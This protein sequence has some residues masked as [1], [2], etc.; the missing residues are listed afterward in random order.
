MPETRDRSRDRQLKRYLRRERRKVSRRRK[1]TA[2][3]VVA[4]LVLLVSGR[5]IMQ[6]MTNSSSAMSARIIEPADTSAEEV[7]ESSVEDI[8]ISIDYMT[9]EE[10]ERKDL[11]P[12]TEKKQA[13]SYQE[14]LD[15]FLVTNQDVTLY[16][17]NSA[18]SNEVAVLPQGTYVETYGE[19]NGWTKVSSVGREGYIKNQYLE[20]I[21]DPTLFRVV[22]GNLIVNKTFGLPTSYETVF[23]PQA[24]AALR[25][26][27]ESMEREGLSVEL[28]TDYRSASDE[29]KELVLMGSPA[30]APEPGHTVFQT[31][32]GVQ[33]HLSGTDP[34]LENNFDQ[35]DQYQW[36]GEHAHEYGFILRYPEGSEHITGY[37]AN[38]TIFVYVGIEDALIIHNENLT[39]EEF[40][41]ID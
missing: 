36:L 19:E 20:V 18:K 1:K 14:L 38:P 4:A 16:S 9:K 3:A 30:D 26:M 17:R 28:T 39:M 27:L 12:R 10:V 31:G 13:P 32:Y 6:K 21:S 7:M 22:D 11:Q 35:T 29:A 2:M 8:K 25:V 37:R 24:A 40:Y 33:F 5:F 41:G 15:C 34:R 23:N